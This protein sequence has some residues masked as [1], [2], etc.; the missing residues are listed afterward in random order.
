MNVTLIELDKQG[1]MV[2]KYLLGVEKPKIDRVHMNQLEQFI[3]DKQMN[4]VYA[5]QY[6]KFIYVLSSLK[7][8]Q[9][10]V[11]ITE[12]K[13]QN[14]DFY[15]K[16]KEHNI[17]RNYDLHASLTNKSQRRVIFFII[18]SKEKDIQIR[19]QIQNL[20]DLQYVISVFMNL[21]SLYV[22]KK[23]REHQNLIDHDTLKQMHLEL[24]DFHNRIKQ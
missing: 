3:S 13:E 18:F 1:M 10:I 8:F 19:E 16:F 4:S 14:Y 17:N 9:K 24:A 23:G 2:L 15:E 11:G 7:E 21:F 22:N 5:R 20:Q 12:L 6:Q